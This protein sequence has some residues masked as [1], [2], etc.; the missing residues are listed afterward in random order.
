MYLN[1]I[2]I[3]IDEI[4]EL[5]NSWVEKFKKEESEYNNFY[6]EKPTSIKLF[7]IYVNREKIIDL[8]KTE[9]ILLNNNANIEKNHLISLIKKNQSNHNIKYKLLSLLKFNIDIEPI[10]VLS[11]NDINYNDNK[12]KYLTSERYIQDIHFNDT[13][14][15]FQDINS[16]F[17]IF[18]ESNSLCKNT[19]SRTTTKKIYFN[20]NKR[21]TI[22]K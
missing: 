3:K 21:K 22:R 15:I 16:L 20:T 17:L 6:K 14:C 8:I 18:I 2:N 10:D 4:S 12:E 13:V 9:T 19:S 5:D 1:N 7:F 11:F